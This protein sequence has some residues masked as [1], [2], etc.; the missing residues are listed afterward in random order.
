MGC[1]RIEAVV[2][3][4]LML[5]LP[6]AEG[7]GKEGHAIVCKIAQA[8]LDTAAAEAVSKLLPK[9][10][11]NDLASLCS[12]PDDVRRAIPWSS[13]LHFADTPDSVCSY[14]HT[15]DCVDPRTGLQNRCVVA[16]IYNYTNQLLGYGSNI[17]SNYNL[18]EAL[19]FLSHFFGDIHQPL[20]CGFVSDQGGNAINVLW[21]NAT[22][23]L[24]RVWDDNIIETEFEKF[25]QDFDDLVDAIQRN[26][27]RVW[28]NEVQDWEHCS[29]GDISCPAIY[30]SES[31]EDACKWAYKDAPEGALL[32]DEYFFSRFPI[33]NLR[34][35]Q[36]GVRL[37]A[38]LNRIFNT[39]YAAEM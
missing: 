34:L 31:A 32:D 16:A 10:A 14:D 30:A 36:G 8:R 1:F 28:A 17:E 38:A 25:D 4:S 15:R 35:A 24:H 21:Y 27:T 7:W 39:K 37:A 29:N 18:T 23:K 20:H 6:N 11:E 33:V 3:V 13:A 19:L 9:S 26:I 5:V 12:W 2:I 22:Q